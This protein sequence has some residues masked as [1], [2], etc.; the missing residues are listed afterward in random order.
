LI[1]ATTGHTIQQLK[2]L[3]E[4][5][6]EMPLLVAANLSL[7][8]NLMMKL[9]AQAAAALKSQD[10]DIEIVERH[11]RFKKDAPSGTALRLAQIIQEQV[12]QIPMKHGREGMTGERSRQEIGIHAVRAGD[13][14][15]DHTVIFS[16]LGETL[17]L[18]HKA[19]SRDAF[20]KGALEAAAFLASQAPGWYTMADVL[21]L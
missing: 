4:A 10:F 21:G 13:H 17:E 7:G 3:K 2:A 20:A 8:M 11:H 12:G 6:H 16:T 15:G 19:S 5:A 18:Q 14:I 9:L 1:V